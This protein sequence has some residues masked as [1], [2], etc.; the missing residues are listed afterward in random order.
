M[1]EAI[2]N[3]GILKMIQEFP[4]EFTYEALESVDKFLEQRE[5]AIQRGLYGKLQFES[6]DDED[7]GVFSIEKDEISFRKE[8]LIDDY[9][10][11][12]FRSPPGSQDAYTSPSWKVSKGNKK[13]DACDKKLE[14]TIK[15][16][17]EYLNDH[18]NISDVKNIF[19]KLLSVFDSRDIIVADSSGKI[20]QQ[21]FW[22]IFH[23]HKQHEKNKKGLNFFTV[24]I[25]SKFPGK[26]P[27]LLKYSLDRIAKRFYQPV[28]VNFAKTNNKV[29]SLCKT[30]TDLFPNVLSGIGFNIANI[31]KPVFFPS[32]SN[33]NAGKSFPICAYCAEALFVGKKLLDDKLKQSIS[34]P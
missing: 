12:L 9:S 17:K 19:Q 31:D 24:K 4:D 2:R 25:E 10:E 11:Y 15:E 21:N 26:I 5:K 20:V 6:I 7:I 32:V 29:C 23:N 22:D 8:R 34:G 33:K 14:S 1:L 28:S 18:Q 16:F 3:L 13:I 30:E 27:T